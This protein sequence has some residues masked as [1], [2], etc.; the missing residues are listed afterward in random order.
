MYV[1]ETRKVFSTT[2][3]KKFLSISKRFKK[4]EAVPLANNSLSSVTAE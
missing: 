3:K 4:M 1:R 2:G